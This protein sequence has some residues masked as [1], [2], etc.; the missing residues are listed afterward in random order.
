[1]VEAVVGAGAAAMIVGATDRSAALSVAPKTPKFAARA[2]VP[3]MSTAATEA[4]AAKAVLLIFTGFLL[5][6]Q[7][8]SR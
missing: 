6:T 5:F 4:E 3:A 8:V 7:V 2:A 1:V